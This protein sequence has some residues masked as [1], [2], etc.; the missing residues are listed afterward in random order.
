M[1]FCKA[2]GACVQLECYLSQD[3]MLEI[4]KEVFQNSYVGEKT[5]LLSIISTA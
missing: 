1:F 2:Y 4:S 3:M 5:H